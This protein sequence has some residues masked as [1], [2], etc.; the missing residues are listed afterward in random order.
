MEKLNVE[1]NLCYFN[2]SYMFGENFERLRGDT[3]VYIDFGNIEMP[4]SLEDL[5]EI[6][7]T[8]KKR[9]LIQFIREYSI[10]TPDYYK[11]DC[12]E[13]V[14]A[15]IFAM[16]S[17]DNI[18]TFIYNLEKF[19]IDFER[20]FDRYVSRGYS[21]GDAIEIF[22]PHK[23]AEVWGVSMEEFKNHLPDLH[24]MIDRYCWDNEISGQINISFSYQVKRE[25]FGDTV[26][27]EF[28]E[29]FEYSEFSNDCYDVEI[30]I[31]RILNYI[32]KATHQSL[33]LED[34]EMIKEELENIDYT[35]VEN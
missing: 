18:Q 24:K 25:T 20:K 26:E 30:D 8:N 35:D 28:D 6:S 16:Y 2:D 21:Q 1:S 22:I 5:Y 29:E 31:D 10:Y 17:I 14:I 11:Y 23:L 13:N 34:L 12:I 33:S 15:E 3:Y 9:T 4:R 19:G 32:N 7:T 27:M